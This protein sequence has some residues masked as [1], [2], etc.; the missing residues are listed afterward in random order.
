MVLALVLT[1]EL[2]LALTH[3]FWGSYLGL[4]LLS[5]ISKSINVI[6]TISEI[7][8]SASAF[9]RALFSVLA[10]GMCLLHFLNPILKEGISMG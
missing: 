2:L 7:Q 6:I 5:P 10:T 9:F 3:V 8:S 1:H 4:F